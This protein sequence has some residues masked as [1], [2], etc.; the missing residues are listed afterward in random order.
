MSDSD[1]ARKSSPA[2]LSDEQVS[3]FLTA[4]PDFFARQPQILEILDLPHAS[5][6][7]AISLIE[8]QVAVLRDRNIDLRHRLSQLLESARTNDR[9]F[10]KSQR[11]VLAIM[12]ARDL[13]GLVN[14]LVTSLG[15]DFQVE[16]YTLLLFRPVVDPGRVGLSD[17]ELLA[18][19]IKVVTLDDTTD[20]ITALLRGNRAICGVL[21]AGE[22]AFL[23][24]P[25]ADKVGSVAAAPLNHGDAF[26]MLAIGSSDPNHYRSNTGTLFLTHIGEILSRALPRLLN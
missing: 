20:H 21:R 23:F 19:H 14:A 10:E 2:L 16:F 15:T 1:K 9:L 12:E 4:E 18:N 17:E 11:L 3:R 5:S 6:G 24:G 13:I 26:G 7:N 25:D 22:L 8:R